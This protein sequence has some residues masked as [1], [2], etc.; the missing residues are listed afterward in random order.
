LE[1]RPSNLRSRPAR[2]TEASPCSTTWPT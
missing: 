2:T 1:V